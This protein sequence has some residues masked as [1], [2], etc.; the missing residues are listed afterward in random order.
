MMSLRVDKIYER[1]VVWDDQLAD[2]ASD[3][4]QQLTFEAIR[5]VSIR[6]IIEFKFL[7]QFH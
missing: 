6:L 4:A 7:K 3:V 5:S 2:P 1:R